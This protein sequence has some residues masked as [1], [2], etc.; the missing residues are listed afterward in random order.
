MVEAPAEPRHP[1]SIRRPVLPPSLTV[2]VTSPWRDSAG[3]SVGN[4]TLGVSVGPGC[5]RPS[6]RA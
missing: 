3:A 6:S 4:P 2:Y 5:H 1:A